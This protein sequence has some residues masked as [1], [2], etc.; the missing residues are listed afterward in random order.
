M[1][2]VHAFRAVIQIGLK[3][4]AAV[5][6]PL[7]DSALEAE[8]QIQ[9]NSILMRTDG[10]GGTA[11][12][13]ICESGQ[14]LE[15]YSNSIKMEGEG[16]IGLDY[17]NTAGTDWPK[18]DYNNVHRSAGNGTSWY[19][20]RKHLWILRAQTGMELHSIA[21]DPEYVSDTDLH[22]S[23]TSG[24]YN[25]AFL[26][27]SVAQDFDKDP[28][29][30]FDTSYDIGADEAGNLGNKST[31]TAIEAKPSPALLQLEVYPNPAIDV[32]T[33]KTEIANGQQYVVYST[34]AKVMMQGRMDLSQRID[35]SS[36]PV[37]M[38]ILSV[39]DTGAFARIQIQR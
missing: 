36:L 32:I 16:L 22:I 10:S 23:D 34:D 9:H 25:K 4:Q 6:Q 2:D 35:M 20:V 11:I 26:N 15:V 3:H 24:N 39:V 12:E 14:G 19:G 17:F 29:Q 13:V 27:T 7:T 30:H 28:R 38:Y 37:G 1:L 5:G 18:S 33:L 8:G 31:H 21:S